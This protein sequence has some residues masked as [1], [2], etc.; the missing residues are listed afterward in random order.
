MHINTIKLNTFRNITHGKL[1][2]DDAK[3]IALVGENGMGKTNMLEAISLLSPGSGLHKAK[4]EQQIQLGEGSWAIHAH[5]SKPTTTHTIGMAYDKGKTRQIKIDDQKTDHQADLA[6]VGSILWFTPRMDRLFLDAAQPR[7]DFFDRLVFGLYPDHAQNLTRYKHHLRNRLKL[8]KDRANPN[9][10]EIEEE[11]ASTYGLKIIEARALFLE[12]LQPHLPEAKLEITG[13]AHKALVDATPYENLL[14]HF[15][16]NR[17][18]DALYGSSNFGPHR[19][20]IT[21]KLIAGKIPLDMTSTGQHK[22]AILHILL[23]N[24]RLHHME[25][26]AT[27]LILLDEITAHLDPKVREMLFGELHEMGTQIWMTG[28]EESLFKG[29][30][31]DVFI[32]VENGTFS[33]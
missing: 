7:R 14:E 33:L 20:N 29:L 28:T 31:T 9:W 18:R 11:Q 16:K 5:I 13:S 3:L 32:Q 30:N 8:L 22:R 25:T 19:T 10:I 15:A 26:G 21:G 24:A 6:K 4:R 1:A 17:E 12:R 27:P 2:V 23:A